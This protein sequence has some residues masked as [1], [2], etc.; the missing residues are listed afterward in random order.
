MLGFEYREDSLSRIAD[1]ISQTPGGRGLTG[2]GGATLP[3]AGDIDVFELFGELEL[4]IV[5]D[6]PLVRELGLKAGYR[7]SDY[8]T[9]GLDPQTRA[10]TS[11]DFTAE[12]YFVGASYAPL[13]DLRFRVNFSRA[14]RA[15][16]VFD[17]F[18]GANTSLT[19]LSTG[20]NG[21]FDPCAS[22]PDAAG[23]TGI[24]PKAS[25]E[26]CARTGVTRAQ[27]GR[28]EDNPAGQFNIITGGNAQLEPETA[29]TVT[30][31][32]VFTPRFVEGLSVS[33]DWFDIEVTDAIG[34][35]PAQASLDGCIEGGAGA[36]V[37]CSLI[38]RDTFG[39]LWLSNDGPGGRIAGISEQNANIA[40]IETRGVDLGITYSLDM[41]RWGFLSIDYSG[42][43]LNTLATT[44]F[45]GAKP[46]E[47]AGF[48]AGQCE[49]PSPEYRHRM[50]AT[51]DT[52]MDISVAMTWRHVGETTLFGLD[53]QAAAQR[54]EQMNDYLEERNYVDLSVNY[55]FNDRINLRAGINN[56]FAKDAPIS[57]NVGTGT[58]NNNTYPG[59]FDTSRTL[60][61][62]ATFRF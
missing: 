41:G 44:P 62:G 23:N 57:T 40:R 32:V 1:D 47:C 4:P 31:G 36:G 61:A 8:T 49:L 3:V 53:K 10:A 14:I 17:L 15:P 42:T 2:T 5:Q 58:G 51:W 22:G 28:I 55:D 9:A 24:T 11:N 33:L 16:N 25:F 12:T 50:L 7:W 38:Q 21:L 30:F 59:L 35:I 45:K 60:F 54:P 20:E 43:F 18:V 52:P 37:F 26:A 46:I 48:Y 6:A 39:T 56:V 13:D 19:D 34:T 27:Y 29:D